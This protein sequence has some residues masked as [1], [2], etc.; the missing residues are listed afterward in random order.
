MILPNVQVA[1][2]VSQFHLRKGSESEVT[3]GA[4]QKAHAAG[5]HKGIIGIADCRALLV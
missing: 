1:I 3:R 4:L 2:F 5:H